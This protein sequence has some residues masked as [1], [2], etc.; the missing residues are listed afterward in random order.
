MSAVVKFSAA[1]LSKKVDALGAL[2]AEIA[3]LKKKA[4]KLKDDLIAA[5]EPEILGKSFKAVVVLK[6][7]V[8]LDPK[9]ARGF[10]SP[11]EIAAASK[12]SESVSVSLF[13]L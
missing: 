9:I 10:L 7:S 2:N 6:S 1:A 3:A 12:V 13:D 11:A 5:G 8:R 4:D